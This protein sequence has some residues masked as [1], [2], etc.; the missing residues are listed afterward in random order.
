M[1]LRELGP[2]VRYVQSSFG[3]LALGGW[4]GIPGFGGFACERLQ[5]LRGYSTDELH[6]ESPI[7]SK[8]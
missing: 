1:K 4:G 7:D 2:R 3:L 8:P 5:K 6:S